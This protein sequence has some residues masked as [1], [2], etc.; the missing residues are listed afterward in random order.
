M[1]TDVKRRSV[2]SVGPPT[3]SFVVLEPVTATV[4]GIE[5]LSAGG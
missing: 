2:R 4:G 5:E 1:S 3:W